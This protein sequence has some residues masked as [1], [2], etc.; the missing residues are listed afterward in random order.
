MR[1]PRGGACQLRLLVGGLHRRQQLQRA[2]GVGGRAGQRLDVLGEAGAAV[3]H[4]GVKKVQADARI[5]GDALA[6]PLYIDPTRSVSRDSSFMKLMRV[7]RVRHQAKSIATLRCA[8]C[9]AIAA[10]TLLPVPTGTVLLS[11][12]TSC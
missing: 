6:H 8:S 5:G 3:A 10:R 2:A 11:M 1:A 7:A 12:P 9:S 4:A